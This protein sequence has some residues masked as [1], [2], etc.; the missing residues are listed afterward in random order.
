M[1]IIE[2]ARN[3]RGKRI[4]PWPKRGNIMIHGKLVVMATGYGSPS[5]GYPCFSGVV[6]VEDKI[7]N[8]DAMPVGFYSRTWVLDSFVKTELKISL[9]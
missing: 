2:T 8:D 4:K 6:L 1:S 9:H 7:A 3:A 5:E